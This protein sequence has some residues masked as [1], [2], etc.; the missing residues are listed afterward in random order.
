MVT[1]TLVEPIEAMDATQLTIVDVFNNPMTTESTPSFELRTY[2]DSSKS[3]LLDFQDTD[4]EIRAAAKTLSS[5]H[6][7][8]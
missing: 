2:S 8:I 4:L 3:T 6:S 5:E 7:T 1:W